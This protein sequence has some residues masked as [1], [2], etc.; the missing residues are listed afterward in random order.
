MTFSQAAW[1]AA[2]PW[3]TRIV[4][5]EFVRAL[6]D[7]TLE[8]DTFVAYL[9][10]DVHYLGGYARALAGIAS[11]S[12]DRE[13]IEL[14]A[15]SAVGAV[16][17]EARTHAAFLEPRGIGVDSPDLPEATPT[18]RAYLGM[19]Q[20]AAVQQPVEIAI[21]SVLPCFRVYAEVGKTLLAEGLE[22]DHRYAAWIETYSSPEFGDAVRA[23]EDYAD[24][25][26]GGCTI[27]RISKMIDA[28]VLATRFEWMFWDAA[29]HKEVWP[30]VN[31]VSR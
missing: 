16:A 6:G 31:S 8:E 24:R 3:F 27:A 28:Y 7:G 11:R 5:H 1:Q 20:S 15:G 14:F 25:L 2:G 9:I 19:L 23:V 17:A 22:S 29:W 4:D 12:P 26:A 10:D 21:A 18:C 30:P 13:G